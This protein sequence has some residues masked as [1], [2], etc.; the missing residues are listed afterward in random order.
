MRSDDFTDII[1]TM[2]SRFS[3]E[4]GPARERESSKSHENYVYAARG[5]I[6]GLKT[7]HDGKPWVSIYAVLLLIDHYILRLISLDGGRCPWN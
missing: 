7:T 6:R 2:T 5:S 3:Q 4:I 1:D